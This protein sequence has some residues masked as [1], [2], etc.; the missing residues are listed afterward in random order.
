MDLCHELIVEHEGLVTWLTQHGR[1]VW[2]DKLEKFVSS[3]LHHHSAIVKDIKLSD[4]KKVL[5]EVVTEPHGVTRPP[6]ED[7]DVFAFCYR[8]GVL[9]TEQAWPGSEELF[10]MFA[11]PL[12]RRYVY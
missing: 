6:K 4:V 2:T 12:H 9:H 7:V 8:M 1:G 11:S 5:R 10:Y 3:W